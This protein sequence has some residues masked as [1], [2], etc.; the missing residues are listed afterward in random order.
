M[1]KPIQPLQKKIPPFF[2]THFVPPKNAFTKIKSPQIQ[3]YSK[4]SKNPFSLQKIFTQNSP[5]KLFNA[6]PES[7]QNQLKT[8]YSFCSNYSNRFS[9]K[10]ST[11]A[12]P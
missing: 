8:Q 11:Q 7:S 10:F 4:D 1:E 2:H 3:Q 5:R 12:N 9:Q 6:H